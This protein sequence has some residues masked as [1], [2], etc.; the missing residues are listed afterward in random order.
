[1]NLTKNV[2][3]SLAEALTAA[4]TSAVTTAVFDMLGFE[5]IVFI[6]TIATVNAGNYAKAQQGA[7]SNMSDAAD[8][9]GTKV[10]PGDD[11]D[12]FMIDIYKPQKRYV[13]VVVTRTASTALGEIFAIQYGA[14]KA[15]VSHG[16]T[17]DS[18]VHI[19]PDEGTA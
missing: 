19:S 7:A 17:I 9:E 15:P 5:G 13:Q 2:K 11:G 3:V 6:G 14:H 18:E 16:A 1:M 12:S 10:V 4:G 8:L